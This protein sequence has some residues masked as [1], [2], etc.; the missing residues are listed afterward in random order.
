LEDEM[1]IGKRFTFDA[2][3]F[4]PHH[5]GKCKEMHGHTWTIEV[6]IEEPVNKFFGWVID[7]KDFSHAINFV[8]DDLDHKVLNE[9]ISNPTCENV[10][11]YLYNRI[12][13]GFLNIKRITVQEGEGGWACIEATQNEKGRQSPQ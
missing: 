5:T 9:I 12:S 6:E 13:K 3:H 11:T 1:I 7:F 8:L 4:L 10:A 2:A